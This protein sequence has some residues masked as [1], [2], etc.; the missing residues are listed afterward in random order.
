VTPNIRKNLTAWFTSEEEGMPSPANVARKLV[1]LSREVPIKFDEIYETR[2]VK[3]IDERDPV[4]EAEKEADKYFGPKHAAERCTQRR[5]E[6]GSRDC[7]RA[8]AE[9]TEQHGGGEGSAARLDLELDVGQGLNGQPEPSPSP[10]VAGLVRRDRSH[11]DIGY[12][13]LATA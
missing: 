2:E 5:R 12:D 10:A 13:S 3:P 11:A 9:R 7:K 1:S 8:Q 4:S 6:T